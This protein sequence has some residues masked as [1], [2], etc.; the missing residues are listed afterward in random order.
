M[1]SS[2]SNNFVRLIYSSGVKSSV[3]NL[4]TLG[5]SI[6]KLIPGHKLC[7]VAKFDNLRKT[8]SAYL[9]VYWFEIIFVKPFFQSFYVKMGDFLGCLLSKVFFKIAIKASDIICTP[10]KAKATSKI[11]IKNF[12]EKS[13]G[14]FLTPSQLYHGIADLH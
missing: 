8:S 3:I 7:F 12:C 6:T 11:F 1:S 10:L 14:Y 5:I 13:N 9:T 2:S 4:L